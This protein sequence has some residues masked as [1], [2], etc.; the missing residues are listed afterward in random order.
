MNHWI[1][2]FIQ[3]LHDEK[4]SSANT[5]YSYRRDLCKMQSWFSE[6]GIDD[7]C[8]V[9]EQNLAS[10]VVALEDDGFAKSTISRSIAAIKSFYGYLFR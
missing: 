3:Y 8:A 9:S 6:N 7:L 2:G 5:V 4:Q 10:Y 1:E